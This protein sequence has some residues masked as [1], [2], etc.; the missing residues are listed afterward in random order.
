MKKINNNE[1]NYEN[2]AG[3]FVKKKNSWIETEFDNWNKEID[4]LPFP[5]RSKINNKLYFRPDTNEPQATIA[6]SR[7][8]PSACV[9]C[10]TPTISGKKTRFRSPKSILKELEN[11]YFEHDIKNFFFKSDTFTIDHTWV[12]EVCEEILKSNLKYKIQW[13]ANSR[14]RPLKEDT[15]KIMKEAGCWLIAFGFETGSEETM[16]KI[17]KGA[18]IEDNLRAAEIV[19]WIKTYDFFLWT[20]KITNIYLLQKNIFQTRD[21]IEH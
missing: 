3:I 20:G 2:I 11:C 16:K 19:R 21:F 15:P 8:C 14:V 6:T 7:G 17:K 12:S 9:Y 10:L 5:N 18:T 4:D 13:V 1:K